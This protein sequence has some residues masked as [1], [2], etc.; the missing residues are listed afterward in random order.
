MK[1]PFPDGHFYSPIVDIKCIK[2]DE[3]RIWPDKPEILGI[4][5]NKSSHEKFIF[6]HFPNYL[7]EFDYPY[8]PEDRETAHGYFINNPQFSWLDA[9]ALFVMLRTLRP[10]RMIEIGSGY[11]SLLTADVNQRFFENGMEFTCVEPYP[12]S[13]LTTEV[14]GI[15][16]II[17]SKVEET[18]LSVFET[19]ESG[20]FL[21]IDSSH[22]AKTGSDI[23]HIYF[24]ILPRLKKG[25]IIH[26]HDIFLPFDYL[27]EW[28]LDEGRSWNEQ[29][30]V[31]AL[32]MYSNAFEVMFGCMHAFHKFP[33]PLKKLLDNKLFGGSSIWLKKIL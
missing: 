16:K 17:Q 21:F 25:V 18:S 3:A 14:V 15:S 31:R 13:F 12:E 1:K 28:V 5:F 20:D 30:L 19:L 11:S 4:D 33:E 23:N 9:R 7:N 32:L 8:E 24:E 2:K 22:V 26:I 29:Y 10:K 6:E 27:K